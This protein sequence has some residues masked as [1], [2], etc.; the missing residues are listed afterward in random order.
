M[1]RP[2]AAFSR[3]RTTLAAALLLFVSTASAAH[4]PDKAYLADRALL[5]EVQR[6]AFN[7]MWEYAHPACGMAYEANFD[8]SVRPVAVGGTGFGVASIVAAVDR[9]WITR[10]QGVDRLL[11]ITDFLLERTEREELHGAFPHWL[12]GETGKA[13]SFDA[14]DNGADLVETSLLMQGLLIARGY[15]N[16]PGVEETLRRN[17]TTLWEGVDWN[18]FTNNEDNGIY[19]HWSPT[20][21]YSGLKVLGYNECLITYVLAAASPTH[22]ISRKAYDYWTSG[23]NYQPRDVNGYR[24]EATA[25]G[26]GPLFLAHYSFIG[27]DPRRLADNFVRRG[28]F[29]R[30]VEQTL[31][32]RGYCIQDAPQEN[33][34]SPEFWGL[35]ASQIQDGYAVNEAYRDS[36]TVAPTAALSS[37]P[38]TPF[39]SLQVLRF[40]QSDIRD[41]VWGPYGPYDAVNLRD[42][43]VSDRYLA[44][45]Q[46]PIV[47]MIENYRSGLLWRLFMADPDVKR[48]LRVAGLRMPEHAS[49]FPEAVITQVKEASGY[50]PDAYDA[51]RHPD[52]GKYAIPYW[53][54]QGGEVS[55][56]IINQNDVVLF[57]R[58]E[59]TAK[60]RN[61][62]QFEQFMTPDGKVA[63]LV[64][65]DNDENEYTLPLRLN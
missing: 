5:D 59:K 12:N 45:D 65:V 33:R 15:F 52:T 39:Y 58:N 54:A 19:W 4:V 37:M 48:G 3:S 13:V 63:S 57:E 22:P 56:R 31:A 34:Y 40:L 29:V 60:G 25:A 53:S 6:A 44:I 1:L 10:N 20:R 9:G 41:K 7:Y 50:A 17:I 16:G 61:M 28:Y 43:W 49:G 55:F 46:L 8:W 64:M 51:V 32:N 42:K 36:G 21:G 14:N 2:N 24:L 35:T 47:A 27:L 11:T 26:G 38:Y 62:L 30:N 23:D 18:F